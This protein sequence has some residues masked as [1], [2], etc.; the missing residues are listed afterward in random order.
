VAIAG[1]L[2]RSGLLGERGNHRPSHAVTG[3]PSS[4]SPRAAEMNLAALRTF[5]HG[6]ENLIE[7]PGSAASGPSHSL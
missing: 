4:R 2:N 1:G 7:V 3:Y 5:R 6:L